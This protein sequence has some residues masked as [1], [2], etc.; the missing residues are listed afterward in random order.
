MRRYFELSRTHTY[1]LLFAI[2]LLLLY[3]AG[4]AWV[5][6]TSDSGLR[7]GADVLLRTALAAGGV[8]GT[9]AFTALLVAIAGV[10]VLVEW[11]RR[12]VRSLEGGIFAGML[13]ESAVYALLFGAVVGTAT[14][15]ILQGA[16]LRLAADGG[17]MASLP[18]AEGVV[19]SLGAGIYEELLFRVVVAGGLFLLFRSGGL[20]RGRAGVFAALLSALLFSAFHY[21]GPYGDPWQLGSFTFRFL[22]GLAFSALFLVRGFGITAWTH[23]LYDV[24]LLLFMLGR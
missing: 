20:P 6:T 21:V 7:N 4:A 10:V 19:L 12:R 5:A 1:S 24:F 15:W 3:E 14:Q 9:V 8:H 16:G 23:A 18:L 22:A 11:R 17:T 2:P 13:A